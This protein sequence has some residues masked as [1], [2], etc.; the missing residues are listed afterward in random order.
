MCARSS[1]LRSC[2]DNKK[3]IAVPSNNPTGGR[4]G[5]EMIREKEKAINHS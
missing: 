2:I 5:E 3:K 1:H 4:R